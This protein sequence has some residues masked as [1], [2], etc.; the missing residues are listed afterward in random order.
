MAGC[1]VAM[2]V[3]AGATAAALEERKWVVARRRRST[4][5]YQ[6]CGRSR[7]HRCTRTVRAAPDHHCMAGG[8]Q[9]ATLPPASLGTR[10]RAGTRDRCRI[11]HRDTH[12]SPAAGAEAVS[13]AVQEV[14]VAKAVVA[15]SAAGWAAEVRMHHSRTSRRPLARSRAVFCTCDGRERT[16]RNASR[17][18]NGLGARTM[19]SQEI[20]TSCMS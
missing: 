9:S 19:G 15:G 1:T 11:S 7:T 20:G 10:A 16:V 13:L 4:H 12:A 5:S 2:E 8:S 3:A 18:A 17:V 14:A 6:G